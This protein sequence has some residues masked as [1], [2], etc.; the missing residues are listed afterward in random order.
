MQLSSFQEESW[1]GP[2]KTGPSSRE[3]EETTGGILHLRWTFMLLDFFGCLTLVK[4]QNIGGFKPLNT[5]SGR[6]R[7]SGPVRAQGKQNIRANKQRGLG[8]GNFHSDG[9]VD[10]ESSERPLKRQRRESLGTSAGRTISISDDDIMEQAAPQ[11]SSLVGNPVPGQRPGKGKKAR[12]MNQVDE[13]PEG[14]RN[15]KIPRGSPSNNTYWLIDEDRDEKFTGDAA[16]ERRLSAS[17]PAE[18]IEVEKPHKAKHEVLQSVEITGVTGTRENPT[19]QD[20]SG[21][22]RLNHTHDLRESSDELQGG[23]TVRPGPTILSRG[24]GRHTNDGSEVDEPLVLSGRQQMSP[25]DIR[26]TNF[27][28]ASSSTRNKKAIKKSKPKNTQ[29]V[30]QVFKLTHFRSGNLEHRLPKGETIDLIVNKMEG[31][32]SVYGCVSLSLDR[33][34]KV[35]KTKD[36][37]RKMRL[38][39]TR[40][41]GTGH[42]LDI[43]LSEAEGKRDL[44]AL[45]NSRGVKFVPRTRYANINFSDRYEAKLT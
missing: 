31:V 28:K 23:V 17:N 16:K 4:L 32:I 44:C 12:K 1:R 10:F 6:A 39:L 2:D 30:G 20:F 19:P 21:E 37:N 43:E 3:T 22:A 15:A 24:P 13:Y 45:L 11:T 8:A 38:G 5:L 14:E 34:T 42:Q 9:A 36:D 7:D 35:E 29:N 18:H 26:P 41:K 25:S 40:T 27:A 33:V